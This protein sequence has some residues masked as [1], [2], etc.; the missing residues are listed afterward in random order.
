MCGIF[1]VAARE[2]LA[3]FR[4]LIAEAGANYLGLDIARGPVEMMKHRLFVH[5]LK[6]A[7]MQGSMLE[8]PIPSESEDCVVS[9]GCFHH[10]GDVQRC[11]DETWRVLKP[12]GNAYLMVYNQ[13]S[14]RQWLKWPAETLRVF[15][16]ETAGVNDAAIHEAQRKA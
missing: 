1:G 10:T 2:G 3:E 9:I 14:Y 13:F 5:R 8:C 7:T 12:D 15:R 6:G 11:F 16:A 4:A